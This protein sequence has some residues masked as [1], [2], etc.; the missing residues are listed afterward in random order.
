M[1]TVTR[2]EWSSVVKPLLAGSYANGNLAYLRRLAQTI[3][4]C[5]E[6]IFIH[7]SL[8]ETFY[9]TFLALGTHYISSNLSVVEQGDC[10]VV[11]A[12][13]RTVVN[14][15]VDRLSRTDKPRLLHSNHFIALLSGL[16]S[17][18]GSLPRIGVM[19]LSAYLKSCH[20]PPHVQATVRREN[21]C[22]QA[23]SAT[24]EEN[25]KE[26]SS[27]PN[28][29]HLV[30]K[31][32]SSLS[33]YVSFD[34]APNQYARTH[35]ETNSTEAVDFKLRF[36]Q[37]NQRLL[38]ELRVGELLLYTWLKSKL[39][40]P[41]K[42]LY[43][44]HVVD[45]SA[46]FILPTDEYERVQ[47][48]CLK[49]LERTSNACGILNLPLW[50]TPVQ[51]VLNSLL[52]MTGTCLMAAGCALIV[53]YPLF[54]EHAEEPASVRIFPCPAGTVVGIITN[55][56]TVCVKVLRILVDSC[57]DKEQIYKFHLIT[58]GCLAQIF[59][60]VTDTVAREIFKP[61]SNEAAKEFF[62]LFIYLLRQADV[63]NS[64]SRWFD[65]RPG[66][67]NLV[68]PLLRLAEASVELIISEQGKRTKRVAK[69]AAPVGKQDKAAELTKL[70]LTA[71]GSCY[72]SDAEPILGKWIE[73]LM[74]TLPQVMVEAADRQSADGQYSSEPESS[75]F[76]PVEEAVCVACESFSMLGG[77]IFDKSVDKDREK[78]AFRLQLIEMDIPYVARV[79][80]LLCDAD[81]SD[82]QTGYFSIR[83]RQSWYAYIFPFFFERARARDYR[84]CLLSFC[85]QPIPYAASRQAFHPVLHNMLVSDGF[86][87][88]FASKLLSLTGIN[89]EYS[90]CPG[91]FDSP[92]SAALEVDQSS[93]IPII[94]QAARQGRGHLP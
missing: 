3:C 18:E 14:F 49:I 5:R 41:F 20:L 13:V 73:D 33:S 86:S 83:V 22:A 2:L 87:D 1:C 28:E 46:N 21:P 64:G 74:S 16:C 80:S 35:A 6:E 72:D 52:D 8:Y 30:D 55:A 76:R 84:L 56:K 85:A 48:H 67:F 17:G 40:T 38:K 89:L 4:S 39:I 47:R 90:M 51:N 7:D 19:S 79:V 58:L 68:T 50:D 88:V 36:S 29:G 25:S 26:C 45:S 15:I 57:L 10:E 82:N 42:E 9:T 62:W 77:K 31:V 34:V 24:V 27:Q 32:I 71:A 12:A 91:P 59:R 43:E 92:T 65:G 81:V 23:I 78:N 60:E 66:R 70:A 37:E 93:G 54:D 11:L 61:L 75:V 94:V 44:L 69:E 63:A 53:Q